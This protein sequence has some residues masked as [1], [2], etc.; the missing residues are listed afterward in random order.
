LPEKIIDVKGAVSTLVWRYNTMID[1]ILNTRKIILASGSPR[2]RELLL[3]L[4]LQFEVR[5]SKVA[6]P[7]TD[8]DP[9]LQAM[10]HAQNKFKEIAMNARDHELIVAADTIVVL[11]GR[12]LGKPKDTEEACSFLG[13]LSDREHTVITGICM[14]NESGFKR[15]YETSRVTFAPLTASE[16]EDYVSTGEPMDKAGAYGIQ[17]YGSQFIKAINGCYFNVMGFPIRKFYEL[18]NT[19]K[20]EGTL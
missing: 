12:I 7:I 10:R 8:E 15:A 2:R 20:S 1:K 9:A 18:L 3:M 14:G 16:I 19:M 13:R 6:E 17:G 4:G 5:I 11:D